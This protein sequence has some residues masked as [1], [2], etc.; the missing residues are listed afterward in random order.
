MFGPCSQ[1]LGGNHST[2]P[3]VVVALS[4]V[5]PTAYTATKAM[6]LSDVIRTVQLLDCCSIF[7]SND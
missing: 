2:T 3:I 5:G 1:M 4:N 7:T 6:T